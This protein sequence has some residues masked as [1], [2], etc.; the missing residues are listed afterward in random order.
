M[1]TIVSIYFFLHVL[2]SFGQDS[3]IEN[4]INQVAV[5]EVPNSFNYYFLVPKSI[6]QHKLYDS[7][8]GYRIRELKKAYKDFPLNLIYENTEETTDWK[9]YGLKNVRYPSK[10]Y[11]KPTSP[12]RS[13]TVKFVKYNINKQ[14]YDSLVKTKEP[15][16]L[17][18]KKKWLWHK[19]RIWKNKK[20]Y[21]E[22]ITAWSKDLKENLEE[23]I[24]FQFSKPLFTKD[25]KYATISVFK[26][27]RCKGN[28]FTS[29]YRK[30]N[31][32]WRKVLEYNRLASETITT[33]SRCQDISITY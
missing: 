28:G 32:N 24:Y 26:K 16:T 1:K 27:K 5:D 8:K 20:F 2:F 11:I 7:L 3:D 15:H 18:V 9:T 21:E 30:E 33:H 13:K 22:L 4:L 14:K 6:T 10:E 12:P 29:L 31:G 17:I 23:K 19:N 25:K